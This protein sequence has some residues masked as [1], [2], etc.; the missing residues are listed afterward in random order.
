METSLI[1]KDGMDNSVIIKIGTDVISDNNGLPNVQVFR[2]IV[3]Q[4]MVLKR[5]IKNIVL[6]TSGAVAFGRARYG[7]VKSPSESVADRQLFASVGQFDLMH[8]YERFLRAHDCIASQILVTKGDLLTLSRHR[9]VKR[10]IMRALKDSQDTLP[11]LNENDSVA[12]EEL[13]FTDND[14]LAGCIARQINA[15]A[16]VILSKVSGLLRD[17]KNPDD[18]VSRIEFG[19]RS[20]EQ[21]IRQERTS[22]NGKGGMN[23]KIAVGRDLAQHRIRTH[24]VS[25]L[26]PSVLTRLLL[27]R[28]K[29]GTVF[30]PRNLLR[31][32]A[33]AL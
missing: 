6:V 23:T 22:A 15:D 5:R 14:Q 30:V 29:I 24:I 1:S 3:E 19:D 27:E 9:N 21:Y 17:I 28:E 16:L 2:Q 10:T 26:E 13:M 31:Y 20:C 32:C 7:R 11:I 8:M 4:I 25:G 18:I 33:T 12:T